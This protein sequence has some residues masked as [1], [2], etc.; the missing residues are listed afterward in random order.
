MSF[1]DAYKAMQEGKKV[2][3]PNFKGYWYLNPETGVATVNLGD[4]EITYGNLNVTIKNCA[5]T[6]WVVVEE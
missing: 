2:K 3:R 6:D 1:E 5:A 4:K